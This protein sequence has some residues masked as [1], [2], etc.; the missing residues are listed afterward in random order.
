GGMANSRWGLRG[1]EDIGDGTKVIFTL[2]SGFSPTNGSNF[3]PDNRIFGRQAW[4]GVDGRFGRLSFGRQYT[5]IFDMLFN[6]APQGFSGGSEPVPA[7]T[8]FWA[9]NIIKYRYSTGPLVAQAHWGP[10]GQPG[11]LSLGANYGA[12]LAWDTGTAAVTLAY[13]QINTVQSG[14]MQTKNRLAA[15]AA[16]LT[17]G[18]A[19]L[20]AGYRYRDNTA[21][22]GAT[23]L[24]DD[25]AWIGLR[26]Q[27]GAAFT[28]TPAIYYD[29]V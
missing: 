13:D 27:I 19:K 23:A 20:F 5:T 25:L 11:S 28:L 15:I 21:A 24:R 26:Y 12:G 1:V 9:D 7:M 10:G 6:F 18:P 4:L 3:F 29:H 17:L 16:R 2:E 14:T 8:S 22:T